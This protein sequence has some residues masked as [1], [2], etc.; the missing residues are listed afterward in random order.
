MKKSLLKN[1]LAALALAFLFAACSNPSSP[2]SKPSKPDP[3]PAQG[4]EIPLTLEAL[5]DNTTITLSE[6]N[7]VTNLKYSIDGAEPVAVSSSE[8]KEITLSK[9]SCISLY[10]EGTNNS[11]SENFNI[12]CSAD[13][14]VY[15]NVMS[16]L[17]SDFKDKNEITQ[18]YAFCGLFYNNTHIK[19]SP[20]KELL[21]PATSLAEG[22]YYM[23]FSYCTSLTTAPV[24][25]AT[26]LARE[27]YE[28][29]FYNCTSL[30]T[31]PVLPATSLADYCYS[32]MF[33]SCTSLTEAPDLPA[34]NLADFCYCGMFYGCTSITKVPALPAT[35]LAKGCYDNMFYGCKSLETAPALPATKL[36]DYCY[37]YM[38]GGCTSLN[39][40]KCLATDISAKNC[41][42]DWLSG[43]ASTGTFVKAAS[44]TG[45]PSGQNGIPSGW[46]VKDAD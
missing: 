21:L 7:L 39:S 14:Y 31:P 10:A 29:M 42:K 35:S 20:Q 46:T 22:C 33:D 27:C 4:T 43:V 26:C 30:E 44:M 34:T 13:C 3:K 16:L 2:E 12:N 36:A 18:D 8:P 25:P 11:N 45:W 24:L 40:V 19:N 15:G 37:S 5:G 38:F 41:L 9:D 32:H 1:A 6:T 23:M 17:S 28:S